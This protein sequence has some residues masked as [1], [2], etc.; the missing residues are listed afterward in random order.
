M[1]KRN[2]G[3]TPVT[4]DI[5]TNFRI[6]HENDV[7][8]TKGTDPNPILELGSVPKIPRPTKKGRLIL[9]KVISLSTNLPR[10]DN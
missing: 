1:L 9:R 3:L 7:L 5:A 4:T 6:E 10:V 8:N 2:I